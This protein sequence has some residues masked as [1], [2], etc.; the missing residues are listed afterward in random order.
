MPRQCSVCC[1]LHDDELDL[2]VEGPDD[3]S[4]GRA[5]LPQR[6]QSTGTPLWSRRR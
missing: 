1:V 5:D 4:S 3:A 2:L 6:K